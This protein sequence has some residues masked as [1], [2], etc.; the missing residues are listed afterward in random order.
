M[1]QSRIEI[2]RKVIYQS[3]GFL[4]GAI[5]IAFIGFL[6]L[7]AIA[8]LGIVPVLMLLSEFGGTYFIIFG[9][10]TIS[11]GL[12]GLKIGRSAA[13]RKNNKDNNNKLT[14]LDYS[15][16]VILM[17]IIVTIT[18][19]FF[20]SYINFNNNIN[21]GIDASLSK[22]EY[23]AKLL[24]QSDKNIL[25]KWYDISEGG[26]EGSN[27]YYNDDYWEFNNDGTFNSKLSG[28][29]ENGIYKIDNNKYP[30][31][32]ETITR[33][34]NSQ[35]H[36]VE[37]HNWKYSFEFLSDDRI[38]LLNPETPLYWSTGRIYQLKKIN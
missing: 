4:I 7:Y 16:G 37:E 24:F 20:I 5:S 17:L 32:I 18:A 3:F 11:V 21:N 25:G 26:Y 8:S 13:K 22:E 33:H 1:K 38:M 34:Y 6:G 14:F 19:F 12:I 31:K 30:L 35:K 36:I 10:L 9:V 15:L 23:N 29:E 2:T 27:Q 28:Y